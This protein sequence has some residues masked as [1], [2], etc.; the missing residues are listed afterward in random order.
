MRCR[1]VFLHGVVLLAAGQ[2]ATFKP[3][4]PR[5][6]DDREMLR[7]EL[8]LATAEATPKHI[9][10]E[11][12]YRIPV[13]TIYKS[14]PPIARGQDFDEYINRLRQVEPEIA[15]NLQKLRTKEDWIRAGKAV[16]EAPTQII[17][18]GVRST[19]FLGR[20]V[21]QT[22]GQV[23]LGNFSCA[24]CHV[25]RLE[26]GTIVAG[27]QEY[28]AQG[29]PAG[30]PPPAFV[31]RLKQQAPQFFATPWLRPDPNV[32]FV[33]DREF[34]ELNRV[35]PG[36]RTRMGASLHSPVQIPD[37]IDVKDRKYLD[38]TGLVQQRTIADLMRYAA[39]NQGDGYIQ[40][41]SQY[42]DFTPR[43]NLPDPTTL[44]RFSDEQLYA[45]AL[46]L[47][48]LQPPPNPNRLDDVAA[49]GKKIFNSL[50]CAGCHPPPTYTNNKLTPAEGFKIPAEH[51]RRYDILPVVVGT[52]PYLTL[53]TRRGTG[54]YKVPSLKGVWYRGPFEHNGS[55]ATLEDWFDPARLREDYVPTGFKHF[56][57]ERRAV[58]GHEYGLNLSEEDRKSLI[59][60]LKTL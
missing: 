19:S 9:T 10:A 27:A 17:A 15:F 20:Y 36:T 29:T 22:K 46:Y 4:I 45:L 30:N 52:D 43:G 53:K 54:Y 7:F 55:V 28:F 25:R 39:T 31:A 60:F 33:S 26:N 48:S 47:Y 18:N 11:Y 37:L 59:A 57:V 38:H 40:S 44:E 16:F 35:F 24:N 50:G 21:V 42:G 1:L 56:G 51:L 32:S 12:Y 6:W 34:L 13:R 41:L 2:Q 8:P 58:R 14:Y 5:I 3:N 23:D 49:R